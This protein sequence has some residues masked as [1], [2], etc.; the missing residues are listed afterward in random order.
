VTPF[1][2]IGKPDEV[3]T[4]FLCG[5]VMTGRGIDQIL[6]HPGNP[7]LYEPYVKSAL[8]YVELAE[9]AHGPIPRSVESSY[10]WGDAIEELGQW[11]PDAR[12]INLE[13][14]VTRS[15]HAWPAK[16]IHYR[17]HPANIGCITA[18]GIDCC[19]LANNHV[20]DWGRDGLIETIEVLHRAGIQTAGA[21]SVE[22]AWQPVVLDRA[23]KG[24]ILVFAFGVGTSGIP[25]NW[26]ASADR[27]G[28][29]LL[30]D[31]STQTLREIVGRVDE[32]KRQGDIA[33]A[34]LHWGENWGYEV[35]ADEQ[36]FA[37]ALIDE[38][39]IDVVHGHSSHH[40]KGIEL[41][42]GRPILYGCGDFINDYEGIG[43]YEEFRGDLAVMYF[44]RVGPGGGPAELIMSVMQ[45]ERFRLKRA[46]IEDVRWLRDML[47]R[48]GRSLGTRAEIGVDNRLRLARAD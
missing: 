1:R 3:I 36:E 31:L 46:A 15:E 42:Q 30:P 14:S 21:G 48:E 38:A 8:T 27:P 34:S 28:V 33:V 39:K 17:M 23:E 12:V 4:L 9:A 47:N 44:V 7:V 6:P 10:I 35:S 16:G 40:A 37:H 19:V 26:A 5:D 41:Y 32:V 22:E 45:M 2:E 25:R 11:A 20:L 13:T 29:N 24:R 18:A 43:G